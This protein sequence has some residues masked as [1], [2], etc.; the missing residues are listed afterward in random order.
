MEEVQS[1]RLRGSS[2]EKQK[3]C[4]NTGG[5]VFSDSPGDRSTM[6]I[7]RNTSRLCDKAYVNDSFE[8]HTKNKEIL[9]K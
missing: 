4:R 5:F 8:D 7:T 2:L 6:G 9:V 1:V 3:F